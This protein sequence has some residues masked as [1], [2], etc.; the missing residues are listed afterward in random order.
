[1]QSL[2]PGWCHPVCGLRF[3]GGAH[4]EISTA[5]F[6]YTLSISCSENWRL[7]RRFSLLVLR[8]QWTSGGGGQSW[9]ACVVGA[10]WVFRRRCPFVK[11]RRVSHTGSGNESHKSYWFWHRFVNFDSNLGALFFSVE[12]HILFSAPCC[13]GTAFVSTH[14]H[15]G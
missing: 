14:T 9:G 10:G 8:R 3:G 5:Y 11:R 15:Q 12:G 1:M 13:G 4:G 6:Y 2:R 7:Y